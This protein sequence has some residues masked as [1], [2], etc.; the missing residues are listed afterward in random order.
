MGRSMFV[1]GLALVLTGCPGSGAPATEDGTVATD[2]EATATDS[3]SDSARTSSSTAAES[4]EPEAWFEVG[5][6][7]SEFNEFDGTLPVVVGPQGLSM[8]SLPLRGSGFYNPPNPGFDN[9][10]MPMLQSFVD[11]P[12]YQ[13]TPDGHFNEVVDYPALF[14]PSFDNPG[15][16]EGPAVWMVIPNGVDLQQLPGL[17]AHLHVELVDADG[18]LFEQDNDLV[19]GEISEPP[20]GP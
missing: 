3:A 16:L 11:V 17:N 6:G 19:I 5:W 9:P 14:Y 1:F 10:D 2:D 13:Q 7:V 20:P 8:F 4:G 12:G 18:L 15:V